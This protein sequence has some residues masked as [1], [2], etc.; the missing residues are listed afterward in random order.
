MKRINFTKKQ[1][2]YLT[3]QIDIVLDTHH[4]DY[5]NGLLCKEVSDFLEY[6]YTIA[7]K[8]K[9]LDTLRTKLEDIN[10]SEYSEIEIK[11]LLDRIDLTQM[12]LDDDN[13]CRGFKTS[14]TLTQKKL[15]N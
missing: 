2:E 15:E 11:L 6:P 5:I 1:R 12:A 13:E 9:N 10:G 7:I 4:D 14:L 8:E 3:D